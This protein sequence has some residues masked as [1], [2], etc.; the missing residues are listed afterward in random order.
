MKALTLYMGMGGLFVHLGCLSYLTALAFSTILP[1]PIWGSLLLLNTV[2]VVY[3]I[4]GGMKARLDF[5]SVQY[6]LCKDDKSTDHCFPQLLPCRY[7]LYATKDDIHFDDTVQYSLHDTKS[8]SGNLHKIHI[9]DQF[10]PTLLKIF[11]S[12]KLFSSI[13]C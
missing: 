11:Q 7:I 2:A 9:V 5:V 8:F 13:S 4:S 3:T 10:G 6:S 1:I 12:V